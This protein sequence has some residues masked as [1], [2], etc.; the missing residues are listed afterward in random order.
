MPRHLKVFPTYCSSVTTLSPAQCSLWAKWFLEGIKDFC[1]HLSHIKMHIHERCASNLHLWLWHTLIE[2]GTNSIWTIPSLHLLILSYRPAWLKGIS[3]A[4]V[5]L[6][7]SC[8]YVL[9]DHLPLKIPRGLVLLIGCNPLCWRE[10]LTY[11]F[12]TSVYLHV[13][14]ARLILLLCVL[15]RSV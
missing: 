15:V 13:I 1:E 9:A 7:S 6:Y 3:V 11:T 5:V 10:I 12:I 14:G 4:C 8:M 2:L